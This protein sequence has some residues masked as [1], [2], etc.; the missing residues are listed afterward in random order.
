MELIKEITD[1][2][3]GIGTN[4]YFDKPY[5]LRKAARAILFND[6][7]QISFQHISKLNH[8]KLPGGG[9][10]HGENIETTLRREVLEEAGCDCNVVNEIGVTIEY[11]NQINLLQ[12][13]YCFEAKVVGDIHETQLEEGEKEIGLIPLWVSLDN[14]ISLL[15]ESKPT[16]YIGTFIVARDLLFLETF[17]KIKSS[18]IHSKFLPKT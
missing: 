12:V 3:L 4:E 14:A 2:S 8:Y 6:Q 17:T 5:K 18:E 9:I 13:S 1:A 16:D 15:R 7:N 11:R 10:E